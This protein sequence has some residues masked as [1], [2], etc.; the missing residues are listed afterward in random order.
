MEMVAS[1]AKKSERFSP[2][3]HVTD[4]PK[5]KYV[6]V[7]SFKSY[8]ISHILFNFL[9]IFILIHPVACLTTDL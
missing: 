9:E 6:R 2:E 3:H 8:F 7:I 4:V 5:Y 1:S